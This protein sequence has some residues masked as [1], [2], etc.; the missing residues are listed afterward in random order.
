MCFICI[1]ILKKFKAKQLTNCYFTNKCNS[2]CHIYHFYNL[3]LGRWCTVQLV[4]Q[5][6]FALNYLPAVAA[7][8]C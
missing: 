2:L 3:V 7:G 8:C 4:Y 6:F 5:S 1:V